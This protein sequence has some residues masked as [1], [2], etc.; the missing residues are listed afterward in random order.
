MPHKHR[1]EWGSLS[2]PFK[3]SLPR[4]MRFLLRVR[5]VERN[6]LSGNLVASARGC[7]F[8]FAYI[9]R[10]LAVIRPSP[11]LTPLHG[12]FEAS[13]LAPSCQN[14]S[15]RRRNWIVIRNLGQRVMFRMGPKIGLKAE[16]CEKDKGSGQPTVREVGPSQQS[17]GRGRSKSPK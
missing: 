5:Y 12:R 17:T 7:R 15:L 4:M 10:Q 2:G 16:L 11:W 14:A 9:I 1:A 13:S 6:A 3:I 8:R